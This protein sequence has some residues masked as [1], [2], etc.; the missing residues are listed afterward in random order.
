MAIDDGR[1]FEHPLYHYWEN[2]PGGGIGLTTLDRVLMHSARH[3]LW[4]FP[5]ATSCCAIEFMTAA[6]SR[7]DL[8]IGSNS[9]LRGL[10]EVY[11]SGD[12]GESG[13]AGAATA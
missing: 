1:S 5:M 11:A 7:V 4:F 8:A 9:Q 12:A 10:A 13:A 6:A 3:S 2:S